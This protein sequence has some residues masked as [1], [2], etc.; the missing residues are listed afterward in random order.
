MLKKGKAGFMRNDIKVIGVTG[1]IGSGKSSVCKIM[2]EFG[3]RVIDADEISKRLMKK[4][5]C[6]YND[7]TSHF[8]T[9]FW[10]ED[11]EIDRKKLA[12]TVFNDKVQLSKL[13]LLV[14]KHVSQEIKELVEQY[15]ED[16]SKETDDGLKFIV[17]DVP[18]PVE[19]GF[20]DTANA[21][22]TVTANNDVRV[23]RITERSGLSEN[24]AETR[25]NAQMSNREY[26]SIADV[27]IINEGDVDELRTSLAKIINYFNIDTDG[28]G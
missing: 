10:K 5:E 25:I 19:E 16:F 26:E 15:K 14:H 24:E 27:V 3:G 9:G 12:E 7:V 4:G 23:Q 17:L 22:W 21:I 8:G 28:C 18:I 13:S 11:G 1:G 2:E 6:A 20:F